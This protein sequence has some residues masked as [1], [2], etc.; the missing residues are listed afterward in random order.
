MKIGIFAML[1]E[2]TIDPVSAARRCEELGFESF[3]VLEHAII[4]VHMK[5][6]YPAL[7]GKVPDPY[8]R[9]PDP[10]VLLGMAAAVT[11]T[12]KLGTAICLVAERHPLA[13]AKEVATLDYFSGGRVLFGVGGGWLAGE[14]EIMGVNFPQRWRV[15][16][17]YLRAIKELWTKPEAS[18]EGKFLKFPP[19]LANPKPAQKPHPPIFIGAGGLN[20]KCERAVKDTVALGNGWMPAV[21]PP[22][23]LAHHLGVMKQFCAEAG[24]DFNALEISVTF[25]QQP[26]LQPQDPQ[27]ALAEYTEAGAHRLILCPVLERTNAERVLE[28]VAKDYLP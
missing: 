24:R 21:L 5:V 13:L 28:K 1:S 19:V 10:F 8:T 11:K 20:W 16:R 6:P 27:R 23:D 9:F 17:D 18:Y 14:S 7:D 22:K 2:K 4:P 25:L 12:L 26:E 15:I 3:W